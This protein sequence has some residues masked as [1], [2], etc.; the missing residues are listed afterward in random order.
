MKQPLKGPEKK[1]G[2]RL[3]NLLRQFSREI[4]GES[5]AT[6]VRINC[7]FVF[8]SNQEGRD[9]GSLTITTH[10]TPDAVVERLDGD[11]KPRCNKLQLDIDEV[12][13][14]QVSKLRRKL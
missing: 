2:P 13:R 11:I 14:K 4:S 10:V 5:K 8:W 12:L 1:Y 6:G 9:G 7:E 3:A